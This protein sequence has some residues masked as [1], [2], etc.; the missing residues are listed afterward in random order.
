MRVF[1]WLGEHVTEPSQRAEAK[2]KAVKGN[3]FGGTI[4]QPTEYTIR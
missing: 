2:G 4:S 1:C 3:I